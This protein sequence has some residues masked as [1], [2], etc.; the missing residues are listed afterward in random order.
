MDPIDRILALMRERNIN[1]AHLTR[2]AG[3]TRGLVTQWKQRLQKPSM[4]NIAKLASYFNVSVDYILGTEKPTDPNGEQP[5]SE[6]HKQLEEK[7]RHLS[8]EDADKA[9]DYVEML[10]MKRKHQER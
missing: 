1:A 4:A 7:I 3:I 9:L 5:V 8:P 10:E 2:E 6:A